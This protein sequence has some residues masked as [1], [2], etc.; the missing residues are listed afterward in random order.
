MPHG[1]S[2]NLQRHSVVLVLDGRG[3]MT[4]QVAGHADPFARPIN[5]HDAV[6]Y[7]PNQAVDRVCLQV[8]LV[9]LE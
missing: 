3:G 1:F 2:Q 5:E 4:Q 9:P 6:E 8:P 7:K